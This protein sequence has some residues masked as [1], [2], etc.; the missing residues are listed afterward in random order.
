MAAQALT[1]A[2]MDQ[3][4]AYVDAGDRQSYYS[5]LALR[6]YRY[7]SLALEVVTDVGLSG[8]VANTY[9]QRVAD[10]Q[11]ITVDW[12]DLS[13]ELMR[14]DFSARSNLWLAEG[15]GA[16]VVAELDSD[17]IQLYHNLV[18]D[19]FGLHRDAWTTNILLDMYPPESEEREQLWDK[20]LNH[21]STIFDEYWNIAGEL[22]K[23]TVAELAGQQ[24]VE[25]TLEV[26]ENAPSAF[27]LNHLMAAGLVVLVK[28]T[29]SF[30]REVVESVGNFILERNSDFDNFVFGPLMPL[31]VGTE[32]DDVAITFAAQE[33]LT[34]DGNDVVWSFLHQTKPNE[35]R[36]V[37]DTG[38]GD[39]HVLMLFGDAAEIQLGAGNDTVWHATVGSTITTGSGEDSIFFSSGVLVT[40]ADGYDRI[41][42]GGFELELATT[43]KSSESEWAFG[44]MGLVKV[45]FNTDGEM[46]I[47]W[48][49]DTDTEDYMYLAD[50]NR[51][52]LAASADLTAGIRVAVLSISAHPL[53][54]FI[55]N[56]LSIDNSS[57]WQFWS[58]AIKEMSTSA[59]VAG[60]DPL[61]LDLDGDGIELT[62]ISTGRSPR[63][64][65]DGDGFAEFTG[66]VGADDGMLALDAN[67]NGI[68]DD[69]SELFGNASQTGFG[70]LATHDN[71]GDGKID[72]GDSVFS[73]LRVWRDL[74]QDGRT[75]AGELF[76]LSD[77]GIASI[78][79]TSSATNTT[80]AGNTITGTGSFT[81]TDGST[82]AVA[83][84]ELQINNV[85]TV[86]TGDR[87]VLAEVAQTMPNLKGKGT[88][89]DL[90]VAISRQGINGALAQAIGSVLPTLDVADIALLTERTKPIIDAW[91]EASPGSNGAASQDVAILATH[92]A[93]GYTVQTFALQ[94]TETVGGQPVSYW[95]LANGAAVRDAEGAI[96]AHPTLA[97][98]LAQSVAAG[99]TASWQVIDGSTFDFL[100]RYF[101][102]QLP[103]DGV[104]ALNPNAAS[105]LANILN[106]YVELSEKLAVRLAVQGPLAEYFEG[107]TYD[108][109]RDKFIAATGEG[110]TPMFKA[111]FADAPA[112]SVDAK[113]WLDDWMPLV[114]AMLRDYVRTQSHLSVNNPYML[115]AIIAAHEET[116]INVDLATVTS[117]FGVAA[118]TL[119]TGSGTVTGSIGNDIIYLSA[120]NST[121]KG[122]SGGDT[123]IV[124][125]NI[126]NSVIEDVDQHGKAYDTLRF[127][128]HNA[129]DLSFKRVGMDVVITVVATGETLTLKEQYHQ[130][131]VTIFGG[132]VGPDKGITEIVFA[133]G[134]VWTDANLMRAVGAANAAATTV[135]GTDHSD[136]I[137]GGAG[138]DTLTGSSGGDFYVFGRGY[139]QDTIYDR[140]A[141]IFIEDP[142]FLQFGPDITHSDL[143]FGRT[144]ASGTITIQIAGTTDIVT[145]QNQFT[146][147]YTGV[148]GAV[149]LD[150]VENFLFEG[151]YGLS[152][153]Q[154]AA[155]II[156]D[157][158]TDGD[159]TVYGF[160]LED[161]LDGGKGNDTLTGGNENDIYV[162]GLGY[163]ND[164]IIEGLTNI[165]SGRYDRVLFKEGVGPE[166]LKFIRNG[167][168]NDLVL[169]LPS[170]ETLTIVGQFSATYT[171]VFGTHWFGRVEQFDFTID[172]QT[173][174]LGF[175]DIMQRTM[176]SQ[177]TAGDDHI[178]GFSW[179]DVLD[180]GAGDDF[181]SG[182]NEDDT[183]LFGYGSGNDTIKDGMTNILSNNTD[184]VRFGPGITP[185]NISLSRDGRSG[186]LLITLDSGETLTIRSQ[187]DAVYT[188][189]FG[190]RYFDRIERFEFV[191]EGV[192]TVLTA[193]QLE[194]RLLAQAKTVGDDVIYGFSGDDA[195]DGGAGNDFLS[196]GD[197]NDTYVFGFGYDHDIISDEAL[198]PL[199]GAHDRVIFK[200]PVTPDDVRFSHIG[201]S[202]DLLV[203]LTDGSTLTVRGMFDR[204][205]VT[206]NIEEFYFEATDSFLYGRDVARLALEG[207][208]TEGNDTIY[209]FENSGD[210]LDGGAGNDYLAGGAGNDHYL[211][212]RGSG[213]DV[214]FDASGSADRVKFKP[215]IDPEDLLI[216][217]GPGGN[218]LKIVIADTG[219]S[220]TIQ[221][222]N[223]RY[224]VGQ[225]HHQIEHFEFADG[226]IWTATELRS[227][228]LAAEASA[229]D[230]NIVG[231]FSADVLHGGAGN[232]VLRGW[233][234]GDVYKFNLGD[235]QDQIHAQPLYITWSD[236]DRVDFGPGITAENV[237]F[238]RSGQNL[239]VS[240]NGTTDTLTVVGHFD[241]Q[242]GIDSFRF[243]DGTVIIKAEADALTM[244]GSGANEVI[245]GLSNTNDVL[246]GGQGNDTLVGFSG[247]DTYRYNLG[248]GHDV[249]TDGEHGGDSDIIAFGPSI[250]AGDVTLAAIGP[251][252]N[253]LLITVADG[254]TITVSGQFSGNG[255]G[256]ESITFSDGTTWGRDV[257]RSVAGV[258][259]NAVTGTAAA[260]TL[261]GTTSDDTLAGGGGNDTLNGRAGWDRY[262][263][264][265][266]GN[267]TVDENGMTSDHD[268]LDLTAFDRTEVALSRSGNHLVA[269]VTATGAVLTVVD[270]F[271]GRSDGI[272]AIEFADTTLNWYDIGIAT[273]AG[274][275]PGNDTIGGTSIIDFFYGGTGDD[276]F[277]GGGAGDVFVHELGHGEDTIDDGGGWQPSVGDQLYFRGVLPSEVTVARNGRTLIFTASRMVEGAEVSSKVS[278]INQFWQAYQSGVEEVIFDD[279]TVWTSD[280]LRAMAMATQTSS[281]NDTIE[282]FFTSD[283]LRGGLGDDSLFGSHGDDLYLYAA[284]DG[285]DVISEYGND[286]RDTLQFIDISSE[287]VAFAYSG[288]T[289]TVSF[290]RPEL[291][292]SVTLT[293]QL[294]QNYDMG[295]QY[296]HFADGI[297]LTQ[298]DIARRVLAEA[299]TDDDDI[300]YGFNTIADLL[301]GGEG[302]DDLRGGGGDDTYVFVAGDGHDYI[303]DYYNNG[304]GDLLELQ[305]WTVDQV[306]IS[307][308]GDDMVLT[309]VDQSGS[310]QNDTSVTIWNGF[311]GS[312]DAGIDLF[313][314]SDGVL[315]DRSDM[316]GRYLAMAPGEGSD[317]ILGFDGRNDVIDGLGGDDVLTAGSG[318][319]R[320]FG[321]NGDDI[322]RGG[323]GDDRLF[324]G[325]GNDTISGDSGADYLDGEGG[326]DTAD[327]GADNAD[328]DF[329]LET[330]IAAYADYSELVLNFENLK[331]G[332]GTSHIRGS[333]ADNRL[334]GGAGSDTYWFAPGA[335]NDT[336]VEVVSHAG[337]D[338]IML[339]ALPEAVTAS[340]TGD[341]GKDLLL[342][343]AAGGSVLVLNQFA[344]ASP[345]VEY[346]L[347]SDGTAWDIVAMN[348][349]A[350]RVGSA[351]ADTITG[352]VASEHIDG[353]TGDDMLAGGIG[354]DR[355]VYRLGDGTDH[356]TEAGT[357]ED[358]DVVELV[359]ILPADVSFARSGDDLLIQIAEGQ[360]ALRVV[361]HF[362]GQGTGIEEIRFGDGT[363]LSAEKIVPGTDYWGTEANESWA[364][365]DGDD[366][367]TLQGG[368]DTSTGDAGHD[369]YIIA[370]SAG[371]GVITEL[372][373]NSDV[374]SLEFS[375]A[376]PTDVSLGRSLAGDLIIT[377]G[378]P[379]RQYVVTGHFNGAG[380]GIEQMRFANGTT[381]SR[382]DIAL[383]SIWTGSIA[384]TAGNDTLAGDNGANLLDGGLGN[385]V[386]TGYSGDDTYVFKPGQGHDVI[387]EFNNS[388]IDRLF[389]TGIS[390]DDVVVWRNGNHV[391]L[392]VNDGS[393]IAG[394]RSS[395][396]LTDQLGA[397]RRGIEEIVF[398]GQAVW[399]K[400]DLVARIV[401]VGGSDLSETVSGTG[402]ADTIHA[403]LG[404][405]VLAGGSGNDTYLYNAG[406]GSDT[407]DEAA[408]GADVDVLHLMGIS[409]S[410]VQIERPTTD[411]TDIILRILSTGKT[412]RLDNQFDRED[413][414]E[415]LRFGDGSEIGGGWTLD[416]LLSSM[417][418]LTGTANAETITGYANQN[419]TIA[420]H[421][422]DDTLRGGTGNDTYLYA[423]GDGNDLVDELS[424]EG[425]A[426]A[427][428][429]IGVNLATEVS[430][431]AS[432][433][434]L[435]VTIAESS[436]GSGDGS[437][438]T[439][440][441]QLVANGQHGVETIFDNYGNSIAKAQ[442]AGY[443]NGSAARTLWG[444][445]GV[446]TL[447]GGDSDDVLYGQAGEDVM[448]GGN[449]DDLLHGGDDNDS[450]VYD[451]G[452]GNDVIFDG[453]SGGN[454][455]VL[456]VNGIN[457]YTDTYLQAQGKDLLITI[458][459]SSSGSGDSGSILVKDYLNMAGDYGVETIIDGASNVWTKADIFQFLYGN[460]SG[461]LSIWSGSDNDTLNGTNQFDEF[462]GGDGN[463]QLFGGAGN[464][465]LIGDAG[466]DIL[467]GQTGDDWLV[468]GTGAD[469]F[470]FRAGTGEDGVGDFEVGVDTLELHDQGSTDFASLIANS[471]EWG[472]NAWLHLDNGDVVILYGVGLNDLSASDFRFM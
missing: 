395:I 252:L 74:D 96:I 16:A 133:N 287:E 72:A 232:D 460:S 97:Q 246:I 131:L 251:T 189:V 195:L 46:V 439:L 283:T 468:G 280:T 443:L 197:D 343:F 76:T 472:G 8:S 420:G 353:R 174:S 67:G 391:V 141:N 422:G 239:V 311:N 270:H 172:G 457:G 190:T 314:F 339:E 461:G 40:D 366:R 236:V 448:I 191:N 30:V 235:G 362:L 275:T 114:N 268:V 271:M 52:P 238:S 237:T 6:G 212:G 179:A 333:L 26:L 285:H 243:A 469:T 125:G 161:R 137:D 37:I 187:F 75:D 459:E 355:Y 309:F 170:G 349:A 14:S 83:D 415:I 358:V 241:Y 118:G 227:R 229:G 431:S 334:E 242:Q 249:V 400:S 21:G 346:V 279:G 198:H 322:L 136:Y 259:A 39:D 206:G 81:R 157:Q 380:A 89:T 178:F 22:A 388:G 394:Q 290:T 305:S 208:A 12:T 381:W 315:I 104:E 262:V 454:G 337:E 423:R 130:R 266:S 50:A 186:D 383:A 85:D 156:R 427:L 158:Q 167:G 352:T 412:I 372:A 228:I 176:A 36:G 188:V 390:P 393:Q 180:G 48:T 129:D 396:T 326:V 466:D 18:F 49:W 209:G 458:N 210:I 65:T 389:L 455:D 233:G 148:F 218:D 406:D 9:A 61:V 324:G 73:Q 350:P 223:W 154:V 387:N 120:P 77:L 442:I 245:N 126:G 421:G 132:E 4:A 357:V 340:R 368:N 470:V 397:G 273:A 194:L 463:D 446:D 341:N 199:S 107:I 298:L 20:L 247:N 152:H 450:Y 336:V 15:G 224:T 102:E 2:D 402:G 399:T 345:T 219:E 288:E 385:D 379:A 332:A 282:G 356:V 375:D 100:E 437:Q 55:R 79:L 143:I 367:F 11:G 163:G 151:G 286:G 370:G 86:Y 429:L 101:G 240:I 202:N 318:H 300:I 159:D 184:T 23:R 221:E 430:L 293:S 348:A 121:L 261:T 330:G 295:V 303:Y 171:G 359:D 109:A 432:G 433:N 289:L 462:H 169:E 398:D 260:E 80:N 438:I 323:A 139:G 276:R 3:L 386:M 215:G 418:I 66:W 135:T 377:L 321:G 144:G 265:G 296:V 264:D 335:G 312:Y 24:N 376:D 319:D 360:G 150:R 59:R 164:T 424:T 452:H 417:A 185:D 168:S 84:V 284:G 203:T 173:V 428:K 32:L 425:A 117:A 344:S 302:N 325:Q 435:V 181:L 45:G 310:L 257:I 297:R 407:I 258:S 409:Q 214:I 434:N 99:S 193:R 110:L 453:A 34:G 147:T 451:R 38:A 17:A 116:G 19:G 378:D 42:F 105:A 175:T 71:N 274:G 255:R 13:I 471:A 68:V 338:R 134:T 216:Q 88:L 392:K 230:D 299:T 281:G 365:T 331:I 43:W 467:E 69:G 411:L 111:I 207:A 213:H 317:T 313:E 165:L 410:D 373:G 267:V 354:S 440:K 103:L 64:D 436:P 201:N 211:F 138:N 93:R 113:D 254:G 1:Q 87:S 416:G 220:L 47:G 256:V 82:G 183:Y 31:V 166:D 5:F 106:T 253:D 306:R 447:T 441:D 361:N 58:L 128:R 307:R 351:G 304:A 70:E 60:S 384:G 146:A 29:D 225:V 464:D 244:T 449:G 408:T 177:T 122:G 248:D 364:G 25:P 115:T 444:T 35:V 54:Y 382:A 316:Y 226:T 234:G 7:G 51:D 342:T 41:L 27:L 108:A 456:H 145:L 278:V 445:S 294:V 404:D 78:S 327:Y 155:Q 205:A 328:I 401:A 94:V 371:G 369:T 142:D 10:L 62:A 149:F 63:F 182:G 329:N 204:A 263:Y 91:L 347:F 403:S 413:G 95:K 57:W 53:I 465:E 426:D 217:R 291:D 140:G 119:K 320:L 222:Q 405:D 127:A 308:T 160:D 196:G 33:I 292:G 98:V 250:L 162:Y 90:H 112:G 414:V 272:E 124:G 192:T 231:F 92:T 44:M 269:T 56:N 200:A 277:T 363:V 419:D 301:R 123:Y 374:D 28:S 153:K